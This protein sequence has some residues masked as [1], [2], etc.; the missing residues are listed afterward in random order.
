MGVQDTHESARFKYHQPNLNLLQG[1]TEPVGS[2]QNYHVCFLLIYINILTLKE[3]IIAISRRIW[4]VLFWLT[5][6]MLDLMCFGFKLETQFMR[7][8]ANP[9][10]KSKLKVKKKK[11]R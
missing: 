5:F 10:N 3:K 8:Y 2:D 1:L 11:K 6:I 4:L 9:M 7:F